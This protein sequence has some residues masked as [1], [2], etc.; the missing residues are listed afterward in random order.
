MPI[1]ILL[2]ACLHSVQHYRSMNTYHVSSPKSYIERRERRNRLHVT[3]RH[4]DNKPRGQ[5]SPSGLL[6]S[7]ALALSMRPLRFSRPGRAAPP[8]PPLLPLESPPP[9]RPL[10]PPPPPLPL[11]PPPRPVDR[12][13]ENSIRFSGCSY[14]GDPARPIFCAVSRDSVHG[15][16]MAAGRWSAG[17]SRSSSIQ[18]VM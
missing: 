1:P 10:P 16:K 17:M 11:P 3:E 18:A 5:F 9:P 8:L 13:T 4:A 15:W 14:R 12:C 7:A 2:P 6:A